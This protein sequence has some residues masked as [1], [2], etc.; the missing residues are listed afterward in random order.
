MTQESAGRWT[1]CKSSPLSHLDKQ[2][3]GDKPKEV[4]QRAVGWLSCP[5]LHSVY[6][7]QSEVAIW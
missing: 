1:A 6:M 4:P 2:V 3:L 7:A 5:L